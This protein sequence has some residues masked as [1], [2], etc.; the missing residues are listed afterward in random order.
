MLRISALFCKSK[1]TPLSLPTLNSEK[2]WNRALPRIA[3]PRIKSRNS[4]TVTVELSAPKVLSWVSWAKTELFPVKPR[5]PAMVKGRA[6]PRLQKA[7]FPID[8]LRDNS[9]CRG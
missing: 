4:S 6:K 7:L 1:K 2:L 5:N 8:L 9:R 3:P